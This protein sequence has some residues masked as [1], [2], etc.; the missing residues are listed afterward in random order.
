MAERTAKSVLEKAELVATFWGKRIVAAEA[1]GK[2][3]GSDLNLAASWTTCACGRQDKRIRRWYA[4]GPPSDG[5]LHIDGAKFLDHVEHH[6]IIW[7]ALCLIRIE[8]RAAVVLAKTIGV[9]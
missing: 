1:C 6:R 2:F 7:A 5:Q 4:D 8:K 3:T 9:K